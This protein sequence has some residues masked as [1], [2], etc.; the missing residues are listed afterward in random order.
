MRAPVM[1]VR[2]ASGKPLGRNVC[3]R[4][5]DEREG[6]DLWV[7]MRQRVVVH[8]LHLAR[9]PVKRRLLRM[10]MLVMSVLMSCIVV[11]GMLMPMHG[12]RAAAGRAAGRKRVV[13]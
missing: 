4:T 5:A 10:R 6:R 13:S 8:V 1:C 12:V 11:V 9:R 3:V 2:V 7:V